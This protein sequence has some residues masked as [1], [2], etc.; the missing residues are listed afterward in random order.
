MTMP[1]VNDDARR[2]S[3]PGLRTFLAIADLW[4]LTGE[5]QR[6]ILGGP[7]LSTFRRWRKK[8]LEHRGILLGRD[9]LLRISAVLGVYAGLK[10]LFADDFESLAWLYQ[11]HGAPS[12]GGKP[13]IDFICEGSLDG[14]LTV[15]RFIDAALGGLYMPPIPDEA[16]FA[17]Y[18]D[19]EIIFE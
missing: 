4:R 15:R 18:D 14:P 17:P 11:P 6:L 2:L 16:N 19:T 3:G 9:A 8:A 1:K 10:D 13:P 12:F 5:Q 7:S